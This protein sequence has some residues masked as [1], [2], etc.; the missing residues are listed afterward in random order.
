LRANAK[1]AGCRQVTCVDKSNVLTSMARGLFAERARQSADL[2]DYRYV[3]A[4]ALNLVRQPW[5]TT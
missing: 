4:M 5:S 3:D 1:R 2:A